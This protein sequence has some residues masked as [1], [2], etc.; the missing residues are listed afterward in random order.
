[1]SD[2]ALC[3]VSGVSGVFVVMIFL[4]ICIHG[5]SVIAKALDKKEVPAQS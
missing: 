1:M 2:L 5:S 4:Q 3:I